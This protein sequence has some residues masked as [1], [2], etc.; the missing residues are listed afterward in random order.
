MLFTRRVNARRAIWKNA[1]DR[2]P[3]IASNKKNLKR[4]NRY[5]G[6]AAN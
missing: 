1:R 6:Y 2:S 4:V 5:R 3:G